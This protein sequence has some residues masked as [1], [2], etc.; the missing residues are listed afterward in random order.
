MAFPASWCLCYWACFC[1]VLLV[2]D[3]DG[4]CDGLFAANFVWAGRSTPGR[5]R[6][7]PSLLLNGLVLS[8]GIVILVCRWCS[9]CR[10]LALPLVS[11]L[12][13]FWLL[14]H[15]FAVA[16][17]HLRGACGSWRS[18][19]PPPPLL[20]FQVLSDLPS[21][22][23]PPYFCFPPPPASVLHGFQPDPSGRVTWRREEQEWRA[24]FGEDLASWKALGKSG[25]GGRTDRQDPQAP[26]RCAG[27]TRG[28]GFQEAVG[29][30]RRGENLEICGFTAPFTA[31]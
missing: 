17:A 28:A 13:G 23:A 5:V 19:L 25:G 3:G 12:C 2:L 30:G 4:R 21:L 6:L 31:A 18:V 29:E 10:F 7:M 20:F 22:P 8:C 27:A 15:V 1:R 9:Q 26:R 16:F 24:E 11:P 14:L